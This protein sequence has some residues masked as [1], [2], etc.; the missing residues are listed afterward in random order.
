MSRYHASI[1]AQARRKA[2]KNQRSDAF[3]LAMLSVRGRFEPPR[4]VLQRLS[5]GDLA[6]YRAALAAEREKHQ[7]EKQP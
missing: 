3:R 1:S 2:A 6:E 5:P 4:W 7:Q